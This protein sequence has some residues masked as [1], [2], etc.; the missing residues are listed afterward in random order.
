MELVSR[1]EKKSTKAVRERKL[2]EQTTDQGREKEEGTL[3]LVERKSKRLV[4]IKQV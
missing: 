1:E 4:L 2:K 3:S